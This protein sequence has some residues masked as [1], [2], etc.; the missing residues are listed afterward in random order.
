MAIDSTLFPLPDELSLHILQFLDIR[1]MC[2]VAQTCRDGYRLIGDWT[3]WRPLAERIGIPLVEIEDPCREVK[4][5]VSEGLEGMEKLRGRLSFYLRRGLILDP[6]PEGATV[7]QRFFYSVH[8][9]HEVGEK[10]AIHSAALAELMQERQPT[11]R[12]NSGA[13]QRITPIPHFFATAPPPFASGVELAVLTGSVHVVRMAAQKDPTGI[14]QA[15]VLARKGGY[16]EIQ[17]LLQ[18]YVPR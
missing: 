6:L 2:T 3:L 9:L 18:R 4:R 8:M 11:F 1:D 16:K 7:L 5:C 17:E 12:N 13:R 10:Y 15:L 14:P